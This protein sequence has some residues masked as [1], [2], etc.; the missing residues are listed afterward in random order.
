MRLLA[1]ETATDTVGVGLVG[2]DGGS[3]ERVHVGGRVHAELLVPAIQEV[4]AVSG[5]LVSEIDVIGVDVGPGLFT[6]L[7]VGVATAKALSQGLGVGV[8][9]VSSL[10]VLAAA[11]AERSGQS[12]HTTAER[13]V[14][15]V[16]ARRGEVFAAAYRF[17][18]SAAG[19]EPV[20]PAS[21]RDDRLQP[22]SPEALVDWLVDLA[23]EA[24]EVRVVGDG[25]ARY[26]PLLAVHPGLNLAWVDEFSAPPPLALARLSLRRLA[27]G[28][29][30]LSAAEVVPDYRR[31]PDARINW[32]QRGPRVP[33][34]GPAEGRV[35]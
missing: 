25:A 31:P 30:P 29:A 6:G 16:D 15:V 20:D 33:S 19:E 34:S 11:A 22:I 8:V 1:I 35:S 26:R 28:V 13:V 9:A 23:E 5:C 14:S 2:A 24:G 12:G 32:E 17:D 27:R 10:D 3:A 21:V 18:R 4:C 7:R